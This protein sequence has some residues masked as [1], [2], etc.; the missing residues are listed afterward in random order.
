LELE[1]QV[2]LVHQVLDEELKVVLQLF[3][4]LVQQVVVEVDLETME[5]HQVFTMEDPVV[6]V[7][8]LQREEV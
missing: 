3:Q 5:V 2:L 6:Q 1:E 8:E 7:V 4:Q